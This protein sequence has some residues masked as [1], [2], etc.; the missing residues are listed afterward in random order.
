MV[1]SSIELVDD[2]LDKFDGNKRAVMSLYPKLFEQGLVNVKPISWERRVHE[3]YNIWVNK[4]KYKIE[5]QKQENG[6]HLQNIVDEQKEILEK[7]VIDIEQKPEKEKEGIK[8]LKHKI[9]ILEKE[10]NHYRRKNYLAKKIINSISKEIPNVIKDEV[11]ININVNILSKNRL[12][13]ILA[14]SDLHF[15]EIVFKEQVNNMNEYNTEIAKK[16]V[17]KL[18][19]KNLKTVKY[20]GADIFY[21]FM[22]GDLLTGIIWEELKENSEKPITVLLLDLYKFLISLIDEYKSNF[23]KV[24]IAGVVGNHG[25]LEKQKKFKN[26]GVESFEYILYKMIEEY[27]RKE[28]NIEVI[29]TESPSNIISVDEMKWYIAHGDGFRGGNNFLGLPA[30]TASRDLQ[31]EMNMYFKTDQSFDAVI[32]GHFHNAGVVHSIFNKPLIFNP[33]IIGATEH[34]LNEYHNSFYPSQ[35]SFITDEKEIKYKSLIK[36]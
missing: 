34:S 35:Y 9:K 4:N 10:L 16:R 12:N 25:R 2:L 36:L 6:Y 7:E 24:I 21:L 18:F 1:K 20:T 26:K 3:Q 28:D 32:I 13:N 8:H 29:T 23:D 5:Q 11:N 14:F 33:S 19:I 15:G 31:K 17:Y 27:Y 30:Q 22:L